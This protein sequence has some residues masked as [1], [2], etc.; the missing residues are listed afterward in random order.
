LASVARTLPIFQDDAEA[1]VQSSA[2]AQVGQADTKA[3]QV[4]SPVTIV[5]LP[6]QLHIRL[7]HLPPPLTSTLAVP[8]LVL[9]SHEIPKHH[10]VEHYPR[11]ILRAGPTRLRWGYSL[12]A[13]NKRVAEWAR[14]SNYKNVLL[15]VAQKL[16][17][18]HGWDILHVA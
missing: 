12:E 15:H 17:L 14:H 18:E 11:E 4:V 5:R 3:S 6:Q 9:R 7:A 10:L 13:Y 2:G 16:S 8:L 1:Q